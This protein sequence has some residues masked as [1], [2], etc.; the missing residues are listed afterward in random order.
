M[1]LLLIDAGNTR[2]KLA[3]VEAGCWTNVKNIDNNQYVIFDGC[4]ADYDASKVQQV[5]VSNVAGAEVER[6]ILDACAARRWTPHFISAQ[7]TQCGVRN[8]YLWSQQL[9]CDRWA[10]LIAA[11]QQVGQACLVVVCGTATTIDALSD[12]GEFLGGLILPGVELM[13]RSLTTATAQLKAGCGGYADFPRNTADA[14][15]SG[16][17]QASCGAIQRQYAL[18]NAATPVLLSGGA[19]HLLSPRLQLPVKMMDNL[20]LHGLLLIA[21]EEI[22]ACVKL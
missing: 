18:L 14:L 11:W 15:L 10:A 22:K 3:L 20:V 21:Q 8:S 4:F 9:G 17:I 12:S 5:W 19:A 13:Q 7:S 6:Q 1:S 16:A 2:I